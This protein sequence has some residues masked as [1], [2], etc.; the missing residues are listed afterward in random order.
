MDK[1]KIIDISVEAI[2]GIIPAFASLTCN[3]VWIGITTVGTPFLRQNIEDTIHWGLGLLQRKKVYYTANCL[4]ENINENIETGKSPRKDGFFDAQ[5]NARLGIDESSASK[6]T[7]G[8]FLKAKEE[9]DSKILPFLSFLTANIFFMPNISEDKAYVLLEILSKLT[10]RQLCALYIFYKKNVLPIGKWEAW[11]KG[12]PSLQNY[13]HL[14]YE[15]LSLKDYLLI[16]SKAA[17]ISM[18][19]QDYKIS[20][21]GKDLVIVANLKSIPEQDIMDLESEINFITSALVP[22]KN[23]FV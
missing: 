17:G 14:A 20:S 16:E 1:D 7:E 19:F 10:Y 5:H 3:P 22:P 11:L 15:F 13:Y 2:T 9:Y 4:C 21:L 6:L 12:T 23:L 8:T 18:G